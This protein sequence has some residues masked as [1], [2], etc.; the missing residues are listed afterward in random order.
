M[1]GAPG[2]RGLARARA[3]DLL[4]AYRGVSASCEGE[5]GGHPSARRDD[6][7]GER[8][9][10]CESI[11]VRVEIYIY[12]QLP[13]LACLDGRG[14]VCVSRAR[15]LYPIYIYTYIYI[16]LS[17]GVYALSSSHSSPGERSTGP[18]DSGPG[19][20]PPAYRGL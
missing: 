11:Y 13:C 9:G 15:K 6:A 4:P 2:L 8:A 17:V 5:E 20:L 18:T 14:H 19:D 7:A 16:Y 3:A 1:R 12:V 10:A